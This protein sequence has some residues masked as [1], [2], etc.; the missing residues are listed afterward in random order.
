MAKVLSYIV[1]EE[2]GDTEHNKAIS[3]S[4]I[5]INKAKYEMELQK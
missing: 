5:F 4:R 1:T 3:I 2:K